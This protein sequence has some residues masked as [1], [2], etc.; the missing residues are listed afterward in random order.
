M[1]NESAEGSSIQSVWLGCV[2]CT[3]CHLGTAGLGGG[4]G[5]TN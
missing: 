5:G 3:M 2:V 1:V 4:G